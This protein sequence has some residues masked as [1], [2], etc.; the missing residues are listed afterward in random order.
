MVMR[1]DLLQI[2]E[3][4]G[5]DP[6]PAQESA[7][8]EGS[9]PDSSDSSSSED[10]DSSESKTST[11]T[12]TTSESVD[13]SEGSTEEGGEEEEVPP[14]P[15]P[16]APPAPHAK[17]RDRSFAWG[18]HLITPVGPDDENPLHYQIKCNRTAH[19][20]ERSCTKKRSLKFGGAETVLL[21]LKYW[22]SLGCDCET[23]AD[24][25]RA[26]DDIVLPAWRANALPSEDELCF[27]TD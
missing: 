5:D 27:S 6:A 22:A 10:S 13:P 26:W 14:P 8:L 3:P 23:Q 1:L 11:T 25:L 2:N 7:A 18:D 24:H 15:A 12:S 17:R 16:A 9:K 20:I 4:E 19:N 21:C